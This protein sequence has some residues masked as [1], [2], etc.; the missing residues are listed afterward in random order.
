MSCKQII[1]TC[2]KITTTSGSDFVTPV[3]PIAHTILREY[4]SVPQKIYL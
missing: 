1:S 2:Q 4:I 3:N